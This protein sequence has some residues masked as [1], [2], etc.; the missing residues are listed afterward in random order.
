MIEETQ[1]PAEVAATPPSA[2]AVCAAHQTGIRAGL[3]RRS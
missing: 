3:G 1:R 2:V